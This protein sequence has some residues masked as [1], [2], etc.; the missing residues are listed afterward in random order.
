NWKKNSHGIQL[1]EKEPSQE[2]ESELIA[3]YHT[4]YFETLKSLI[5]TL[6]IKT[7]KPSFIDLHSMPSKPTAYHLSVTP[8]QSMT[9]P[10]F[11]VSDIIGK[12]CEKPFIDLVC[13]KLSK[14]YPN[15]TQNDPY[16]GGFI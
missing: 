9:R 3:K 12:S 4:P 8:N 11:C 16:F 2:L 10:D 13:E 15:V 7:T 1:V 5:E 6:N 14:Y